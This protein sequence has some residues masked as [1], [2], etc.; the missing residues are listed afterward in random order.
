MAG[1]HRENYAKLNFIFIIIPY[2]SVFSYKNTRYKD[3]NR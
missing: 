3:T 1:I 2:L